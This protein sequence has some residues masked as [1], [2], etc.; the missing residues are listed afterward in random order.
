MLANQNPDAVLPAIGLLNLSAALHMGS[1]TTI[2]LF[3]NNVT[4]KVYYTDLED[5][6]SGPWGGTSAIVGQPA[7]DAQRY[8][9]LR[10]TTGF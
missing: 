9:G 5:F 10:F 1:K 2:T 3:V 8:A 7:R 6:W 4:D